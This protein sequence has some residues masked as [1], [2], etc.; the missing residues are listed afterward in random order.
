M[1]KL[2]EEDSVVENASNQVSLSHDSQAPNSLME[3]SGEIKL[4]V[5]TGRSNDQ[6]E[7]KEL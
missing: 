7:P 3:S 2:G 1:R 6:K 4:I 5:R